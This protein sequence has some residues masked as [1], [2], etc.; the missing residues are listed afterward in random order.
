MSF[1]LRKNVKYYAK[2]IYWLLHFINRMMG[3]ADESG[4]GNPEPAVR[5]GA[6]GCTVLRIILC[7]SAVAVFV[8]LQIKTFR[9]NPSHSATE[10]VFPIQYKR[11]S[12]DPHAEGVKNPFHWGVR[13]RSQWPC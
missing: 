7:L 12:G 10:L 6:R 1:G 11:F 13:S 5:K 3:S 8:D 9:P 4:G 2:I